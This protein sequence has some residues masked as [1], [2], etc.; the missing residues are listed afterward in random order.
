MAGRGAGWAIAERP[1]RASSAASSSCE[2]AF[3]RV[4]GGCQFAMGLKTI[5]KDYKVLI[6]MGTGL[7]LV[8]WGWFYIKSS[9]LFQVKTEDYVPEPGI[10]TYVMQSDQKNKE[11]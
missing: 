11:K 6:V 3:E 8:H 1:G 5:W 7:G 2:G 9:P 4:G 10:V